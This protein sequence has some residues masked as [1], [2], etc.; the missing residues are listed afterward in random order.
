MKNKLAG[1]LEKLTNAATG[2]TTYACCCKDAKFPILYPPTCRNVV[3]DAAG[4]TTNTTR[5]ACGY[6][7]DANGVEIPDTSVSCVMIQGVCLSNPCAEPQEAPNQPSNNQ[8]APTRDLIGCDG[9]PLDEGIVPRLSGKKTCAEILRYYKALEQLLERCYGNCIGDQGGQGYSFENCLRGTASGEVSIENIEM[10]AMPQQG[11]PNQGRPLSPTE[12][13][14]CQIAKDR[15]HCKFQKLR[16]Q[17]LIRS[18]RLAELYANGCAP[19]AFKP[20]T[21]PIQQDKNEQ[22]IKKKFMSDCA[23]LKVDFP[24]DNQC[25]KNGNQY[26]YGLDCA[27]ACNC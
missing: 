6:K 24:V 2:G 12:Q 8:P 10:M 13:R 3:I 9:K 5:P 19:Y 14:N 23:K 7:I 11:V 4:N 17:Y 27:K 20:A 21:S 18:R 22:G 26:I 25:A 1:I 16:Y 15:C